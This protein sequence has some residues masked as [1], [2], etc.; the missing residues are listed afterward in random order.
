MEMNQRQV[1]VDQRVDTIEESLKSL[2]VSQ[3]VARTCLLSILTVGSNV[4]KDQSLFKDS[5]KL[6]FSVHFSVNWKCYQAS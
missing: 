3:T 5:L 4:Y 6:H 2:Q 1:A